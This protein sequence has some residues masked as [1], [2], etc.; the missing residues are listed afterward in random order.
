M[1]T[2]A[3]RTASNFEY[4][5]RHRIATATESDRHQELER[6]ESKKESGGSIPKGWGGESLIV[7]MMARVT[8]QFVFFW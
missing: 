5:R 7:L 2:E 4:Y 6:D 3:V 8:E 1:Q